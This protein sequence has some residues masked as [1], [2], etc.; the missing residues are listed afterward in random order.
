M[1]LP[2]AHVANTQTE[3]KV[4]FLILHDNRR[5]MWTRF[6]CGSR[7][8]AGEA[9]RGPLGL[10]KTP[11]GFEADCLLRDGRVQR[12]KREKWKEGKW[13]KESYLSRISTGTPR[14]AFSAPCGLNSTRCS[15]KNSSNPLLYIKIVSFLLLTCFSL[16]SSLCR[17]P[18]P[19]WPLAPPSH[20]EGKRFPVLDLFFNDRVS[21]IS[22]GVIRRPLVNRYKTA[23]G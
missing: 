14:L 6:V 9:P 13:K 17:L 1:S 16:F 23:A 22:W 2:Q 20:H 21:V 18:I 8:R 4:V 19:D 7:T 3:E 10:L 15:L 5:R 12:E 11:K